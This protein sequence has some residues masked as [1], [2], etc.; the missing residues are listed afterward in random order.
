MTETRQIK[1]ELPAHDPH[2]SS[3]SRIL[4]I[5]CEAEGRLKVRPWV[6]EEH[7][8]GSGDFNSLKSLFCDSPAKVAPGDPNA[9]DGRTAEVLP[10][11][12]ERHIRLHVHIG[13]GWI[14]VD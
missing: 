14:R 2:H 9:L 3:W 12:L 7:C 4:F 5:K 11:A 8:G 6:T 13:A 10:L 1:T